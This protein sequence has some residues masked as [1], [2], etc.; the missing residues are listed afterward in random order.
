MNATTVCYNNAICHT[1]SHTHANVDK[2]NNNT[3]NSM[4]V[5]TEQKL[6]V[7]HSV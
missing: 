3:E 6:K 2:K 4:T 5:Y 1:E 7:H